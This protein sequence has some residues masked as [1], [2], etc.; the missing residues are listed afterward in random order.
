MIFIC[1]ESIKESH[2]GIAGTFV[3]KTLAAYQNLAKLQ[4]FSLAQLFSLRYAVLINILL[5]IVAI[6]LSIVL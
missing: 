3:R 4:N 2:C 1:M 5:P 6:I